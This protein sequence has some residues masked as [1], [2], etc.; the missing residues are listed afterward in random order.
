M[1]TNLCSFRS[2]HL[3][4]C[5]ILCNR[6]RTAANGLRVLANS[7]RGLSQKNLRA[8]H[9]TCVLPIITWAAVLWFRHDLPRKNLLNKLERV[10]NISLRLVCGAFKTTP[11][12]ALQVLAHQPPIELTLTRFA[13]NAA[14]RLSRTPTSSPVFQR[15]PQDW[16]NGE[17]GN[18]PIPP[19]KHLP[20]NNNPSSRRSLTALEYL[21]S[22]NHPKGERMFQFADLNS[23]YAPRLLEH[24]R[25][26]ADTDAIPKS[27]PDRLASLIRDINNRDDLA[28]DPKGSGSGYH[29]YFCDGSSKDGRTGAGVYHIRGTSQTYSD[30]AIRDGRGDSLVSSREH[31]ITIGG[32]RKA[33]S[34]DAEMLALVLASKHIRDM[35]NH[36]SPRKEINIF[37]D[38][39]AALKLIT[40]PSPHP[41]QSMSPIFIRNIFATLDSH[42]NLT[43]TMDWCPGHSNVHGNERADLLAND[44]RPLKGIHK[45]ATITH[46]KTKSARRISKRW[47]RELTLKYRR[48]TG[49]LDFVYLYPLTPTPTALFKETTRELFGRLTQTLTGHGYTGE[50]YTKFHIADASPWCLCSTSV[51]APVFHSRRHVLSQCPRHSQ[52]RSILK[53]ALR[54]PDLD[55]R[56][57][58]DPS[59]LKSLLHFMHVSG[60]FTK[61]D[62]PFSLDLILP[63]EMRERMRVP[64]YEPP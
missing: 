54:D 3:G 29:L 62:R 21:S 59:S 43:I 50:F 23:P 35:S 11:V 63:P 14:L 1:A 9:K 38:S 31:S 39:V 25:F 48:S 20:H 44:A 64:C 60:A 17:R 22:L 52:F 56:M 15:L 26:K 33:T 40:D 53:D 28:R 41:A 34:F 32:G 46:M 51:G 10:Q 13:S 24:K 18:A 36:N 57:L 7:V 5:D 45:H 42:P 27:D 58:G 4:F 16:R 55:M 30:S 47:R 49:S 2:R 37:S 8:L 12:G 19:L 61:L 6:A